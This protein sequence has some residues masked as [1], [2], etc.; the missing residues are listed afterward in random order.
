M[1]LYPLQVSLPQAVIMFFW[2]F[3]P[4]NLLPRVK[5]K[6]NILILQDGGPFFQGKLFFKKS[7]F[8]V[9]EPFFHFCRCYTH[10]VQVSVVASVLAWKE[11][12]I[13]FALGTSLETS[14]DGL[15]L[16]YLFQYYDCSILS[17]SK[18]L[19]ENSISSNL[20]DWVQTYLCI[21]LQKAFP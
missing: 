15:L 17:V 18:T 8:C 11:T 7:K 13:L 14:F 2:D 12:L 1:Q 5:P 19:S 21:W 3:L 4:K 16:C 10:R 9:S 6:D 20:V